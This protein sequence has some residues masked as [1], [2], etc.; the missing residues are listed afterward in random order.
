MPMRVRVYA[1]LRDF[2]GVS[3]IDLDSSQPTDVRQVL[4]QAVAAYPQLADKLWDEH[5]RLSGSV[6]VLVNGRPIQ[7]L[8]GPETPVD[9]A[10][11]VDLFPPIGGR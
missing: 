8:A 5:E 2:L 6:L 9:P 10:D 1:T 7:F 11:N 4:R 3:A